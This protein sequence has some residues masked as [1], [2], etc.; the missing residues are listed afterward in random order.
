MRMSLSGGAMHYLF[1]YRQQR[2][3]GAIRT[4][5]SLDGEAVLESVENEAGVDESDPVLRWY[6]DVYWEGKRLPK[7]AEEA[8]AWLLAQSAFVRDA[9]H[10]LADDMG[11]GMD[12]DVPPL[13]RTIP[14]T[15]RGLRMRITLAV[16]NRREARNAANILRG[17]ADAWEQSLRALTPLEA[18]HR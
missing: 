6:I 2:V 3:D 1:Y 7:E 9:L 11:A 8:R 18:T 13:R 15:P 10:S 12:V 4:G 17:V 16:M 14:G 5:I